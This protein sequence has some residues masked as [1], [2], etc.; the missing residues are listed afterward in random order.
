VLF[1]ASRGAVVVRVAVLCGLV[2]EAAVGWCIPGVAGDV[3]R[4]PEAHRAENEVGMWARHGADWHARV[5]SD[6]GG[7]TGWVWDGCCLLHVH[8]VP[9]PMCSSMESC[10]A[11]LAIDRSAE[12]LGLMVTEAD[13]GP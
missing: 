9:S 10:F 4:R 1:C 12:F 8:A 11:G 5:A 13:D 2:A 3:L 6:L 7:H